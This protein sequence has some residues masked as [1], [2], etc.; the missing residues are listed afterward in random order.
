[1]SAVA[2]TGASGFVGHS[3]SPWLAARGHS[4]RA[5]SRRLEAAHAQA[6]VS[7]DNRRV[8]QSLTDPAWRLAFEKVE[9]VVHLAALAHQTGSQ[10]PR[11]YDE[12]NVVGTRNIVECA[13]AAGVRR[14]VFLSTIKVNGER[15]LAGQPFTADSVPAPVDPYGKSKLAAE[16]IVREASAAGRIETIVIRPV[17][18]YGPGVRANFARLLRWVQA[19]VPLPFG[20]VRNARSLLFIDNL[21]DLIDICT[22]HERA[23]GEIFLAADTEPMS[24]PDL[25]RA[26]AAGLGVQ[27]RLVSVPPSLLNGV[28]ACLGQGETMGRLTDSLTVDLRKNEHVLGWT[29]PFSTPDGLARTAA[30]FRERST[31]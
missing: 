23:N 15:T 28:A 5:L 27:P 30:W 8:P 1:M 12:V 18:V 19:G 31:T 11:R 17:L 25:V 24:T 4:V 7:I 9:C 2:I 13:I 16:E 14:F 21:C 20:S 26:L 6:S 22:L 3:L 29:P 10:D